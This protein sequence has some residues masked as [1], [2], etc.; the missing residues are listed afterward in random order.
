MFF[1]ETF[2]KRVKTSQKTHSRANSLILPPAEA[3][4][5]SI[6]NSAV[7]SSIHD[8]FSLH[9]HSTAMS[10]PHQR[11][12]QGKQKQKEKYIKGYAFFAPLTNPF[13]ICSIEEQAVE[14]EEEEKTLVENLLHVFVLTIEDDEP[15]SGKIY[16]C[17]KTTAWRWKSRSIKIKS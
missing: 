1:R 3:T 17:I 5:C 7:S 6:Q 12:P 10:N 16:T 8:H 11:H 14:A 2:R 4:F 9:S 15:L 13:L